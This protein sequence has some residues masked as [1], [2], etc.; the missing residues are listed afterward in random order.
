MYSK[1]NRSSHSANE[2]QKQATAKT[3][4]DFIGNEYAI[5]HLGWAWNQ[6]LTSCAEGTL[7]DQTHRTAKVSLAILIQHSGFLTVRNRR[8]IPPNAIFLVD[9]RGRLYFSYRN[10]IGSNDRPATAYISPRDIT[11]DV[12]GLANFDND[13]RLLANMAKLAGGWITSG[14]E[15]VVGQWLRFQGL[16]V[17]DN[18]QDTRSLLDLLNFSTLPERPKYGNYWEL[19]DAPDDSPFKLNEKNRAI[20]R[21]V[22]ADLTGGDT[23][24]VDIFGVHLILESA[25]ADGFPTSTDYRIQRLIE[26]AVW[27]S[28]QAQ[29]YL[30]ALGWFAEE[31]EA[32]PTPELVEQLLIAALLLDLDPSLDVANTHF[33]GFDLYSKRHFKR[34]PSYVRSQLEKHLIDSLNLNKL[35][36]PLVA[37]WVLGGMAPEYLFADWP[38]GLQMGTPAWVV[39]TQAV[40]FVEALIPGATRKMTYQHLMGFGQSAKVTS[41]L[42]SLHASSSVD[43]VVTWAWMN[44]LI[45]RDAEGTVS[46]EAITRATQEYQ[47]YV[48][49]M[50]SAAEAFSR[51]LPDRKQLAL[52][53]LKSEVP[54][55]DPNELLVKH[56]G[57]GGGGGRKVSVLDLYMGDELHTQDWDR[58]RG[59]SIYKSFPGLNELFPVAELYEPA[60][61]NHF[62]VITAALASNIQAAL[63][64]LHREDATFI[65]YGAL[66][67]YCVQKMNF[68]PARTTGR[69]GISPATYLPGET[70][71]YGVI[72]SAQYSNTIKCFELFPLRMECRYNPNLEDIFDPLVSGDYFRLETK[73]VDKKKLEN[74]SI[75]IQAYLQNLAPRDNVNSRVYIRKI[76]EL[77]APTGDADA[78]YPTPHFRSRRKE[79]LSEL[80]AEKNPYITE[81]EIRQ[82]GLHQTKR[83]KAIEKTEAI[84]DTILN[85]IIPFKG[86]VEGLSSGDAKKQ[87][88]AIFDCIVDAAVLALTFAAAPVKIVAVST[89]A[90]TMATRLLS[91]SRVLAGTTLSLFN[92][93]SGLPQLL[94]GGGKLLGRGVSKLSGHALST[95]R[96]ARQ[97]LRYL[98]GANS[99]NLLKAIDHTGSASQIRMSLDAVGHGRALFKSDLIENAEQILRGL[100][101]NDA[102]LLG[103]IPEQELAHLLENTLADIALKSDTVQSLKKVLDPQVVES[104]VKQQAQK[105]NLANLHQF[106][107]HTTL[108]ELFDTT[109]QIEF[110]NLTFMQAHQNT[111]IAK[112][113]GKAPFDSVL[114]EVK[115]NP[116]GLTDS[117][118]RATAWILNASSSRNELDSVKNLL[119]EYSANSKRLNDPLIYAELHRR[120]APRDAGGLR[121]PTGEARYPSNVSG[122]ALLEKH[123]TALDPANEHFAKQM[124]GAMLGYHS[125]VDGNGR[126]ARAVYA[127]AELRK[128]RFN[129]L[130]KASEDALSG[131]A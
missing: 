122:A 97:Q 51:P 92:P 44:G 80:I 118:D 55:C 125:F 117:T 20:I 100:H 49:K 88:A 110:K 35:F 15:I 37:E 41:P 67:I 114:D 52:N 33:A 6:I 30:D 39:G 12:A 83:E 43:P 56:R 131:L 22:T 93:L 59:I 36:A 3:I 121:S 45:M 58:I 31:D 112:D 129:A 87:G 90:A 25:S 40:H 26:I 75:D 113:L 9:D 71:R 46:Q 99:Y 130:G 11:A 119:L 70:G 105:Y 42:A 18:E 21:Q 38:S 76:G 120:I 115:F 106:G 32:K 77:G 57:S 124:L 64:Q 66:G 109:L 103:N 116:G 84:F 107:D 104:L 29:G 86:C 60:I 2:L 108:P 89:K 128:G 17:P 126:T 102:K 85:L 61:Y 63:S 95:S 68:R 7:F 78:E 50:L 54:D 23:S 62:S 13:L 24:L 123:A 16:Q 48:D 73:F 91:A 47:Q 127:I 53:E 79:A 19:L 74:V 8:A 4:T 1:D 28:G 81:D 5:E 94:K 69:H 98:T 14:D 101:A 96:Q 65:E 72:I 111:L 27:A 34:H 82:L 10:L